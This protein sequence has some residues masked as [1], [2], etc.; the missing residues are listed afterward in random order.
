[1]KNKRKLLVGVFMILLLAGVISFVGMDTLFCLTVTYDGEGT[2]ANPYEVENVHQLQCINEQSLYADYVQVSDINAS[3]T[4]SWN[5]GKGFEPIGGTFRGT[6]NGQDYNITDLTIDRREDQVGLFDTFR[7]TVTN[8]SVVDAN[9]TGAV[10]VGG[11]IGENNGGTIESS[12]MTG[13]VVGSERVGG[14]VGENDIGSVEE[15]QTTVSVEGTLEVG[16]LVGRNFGGTINESYATGSVNGYGTVGGLVGS[17]FGGS[18]I[19]TYATASVSNPSYS[20]AR[21]YAGGLVGL[22]QKGTINKSYSTGSVSGSERV[23]GF[24]GGNTG[25]VEDSYWDM[26]TTRQSTSAG[27]GTGLTT[28]EM[29]GSAAR[30]NMTGFDFTSTWETVRGDY[31]VLAWQA[32]RDTRD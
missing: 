9:I 12:Y 25:T 10:F 2:E 13:T 8:V 24:V 5:G 11:L 23:G 3:E 17:S 28:A 1:M 31:P 21:S 14:L 29:T 4:S 22:N 20:H 15:S 6:F 19:N 7:G 16:G 30:G 32:E 18:I 26:N 27:N